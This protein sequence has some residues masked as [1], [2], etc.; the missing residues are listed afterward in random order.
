MNGTDTCVYANGQHLDL[1][2]AHMASVQSVM[3]FVGCTGQIKRS[4]A[5]IPSGTPDYMIKLLSGANGGPLTFQGCDFDEEGYPRPNL[6]IFYA[7]PSAG[8][9][10]SLEIRDYDPHEPSSDF[11]MVELAD[12]PGNPPNI[13][14]AKLTFETGSV[15]GGSATV[16]VVNCHSS[17]WYGKILDFDPSWLNFLNYGPVKYDGPENQCHIVAICAAN[18]TNLTPRPS[19]QYWSPKK[20]YGT[21]ERVELNGKYYRAFSGNTNVTPGTNPKIWIPIK[22]TFL[23]GTFVIRPPNASLQPAPKYTEYKCTRTGTYGTGNAEDE[24]VFTGSNPLP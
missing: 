22:M 1:L 20:A 13:A 15:G 24:P 21:N 3:C 23:A 7:E 16:S 5:E 10:T 9:P 19:Y 18:H 12:P 17:N 11:S 14:P 4:M 2:N 6:A 8:D